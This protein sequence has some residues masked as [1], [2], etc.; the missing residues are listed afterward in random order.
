MNVIFHS[1]QYFY[2][3]LVLIPLVGISLWSYYSRRHKLRDYAGQQARKIMPDRIGIK[4]L[5][6]D[7]L[8][9]LAVIVLIV[10]LARPQMPSAMSGEDDQRGVEAIF[11]VD[12]SNSMLCPDLAPSRLEFTK[13]MLQTLLGRMKYDKVG[14]VIFAAKAYVHLPMTTDL[15]TA[16]EF[17]ADINVNM[18]SAQG[19]AIGEAIT[20]AQE[21]FSDDKEIGKTIVVLTDGENHEDDAISSAKGAKEAGVKVQV[22]GIGTKEGGPIPISSNDYLKDEQG[23]VVTTH[24]SPSMCRDIAEAGGGAFITSSN[25]S[26]VVSVLEDQIGL[27]PKAN[28]GQYGSNSYT[29]YYELLAFLALAFILWELFVSERRNK[30]FGKRLFDDDK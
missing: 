3:L 12:V 23:E 4:R 10:A 24:F 19:T 2:W 1:P 16:Q 27:L 7:L 8:L 20:L 15:K 25:L 26:S 18:L 21:A 11:C 5:L 28:T 14:I 29:E 30:L 6:K 9:A 17:I 22:V 13:R